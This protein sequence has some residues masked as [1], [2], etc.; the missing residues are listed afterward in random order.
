MLS[1]L[2][3][4]FFLVNILRDYHKWVIIVLS[5]CPFLMQF[6]LWQ[7]NLLTYLYLIIILLFPIKCKGITHNLKHFPLKWACIFIAF[8]LFAANYFAPPANKHTPATICSI[9]ENTLIL[10][11]FYCLYKQRPEKVFKTF[12]HTSFIFGLIT[13][14]YCLFEGILHIN[15]YIDFMNNIGV[16]DSNNY[17]E[18]RHGIKRV[19]AFY[20]I[21]TSIAG[22]ALYLI[23]LFISYVKSKRNIWKINYI[24]YIFLLFTMLF[25]SGMRTGIVCIAICLLTFVNKQI[26]TLKNI[27]ICIL[28]YLCISLAFHDYINSF[29]DSMIHT[30]QVDGST[31][32]GREK[33]W[34]IA[35]LS[36]VESPIWGHGYGYT[37]TDLIN[38][39]P[40]IKGAD[41]L[42]IILMIEQGIIGVI[43]YIIFFISLFT[44]TYKNYPKLCFFIAGIL[45][46]QTIAS[47]TSFNITHSFFYVLIMIHLNNISLKN[48]SPNHYPQKKVTYKPKI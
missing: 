4:F 1:L 11:I 10:Y 46:S 18:V 32:S 14:V 23:P 7:Q 6:L 22:L 26:F 12:I 24:L 34:T 19:Q 16:Y 9:V 27:L 44:F 2:I 15:P 3:F 25:F 40:Q 35:F 8:S 47:I 29:L 36:F 33:Q 37:F 13:C 45:C 41:S 39:Y 38:I 17:T 42:W 48:I 28:L 31:E 20:S 21:Y 30:D 5:L 43:S